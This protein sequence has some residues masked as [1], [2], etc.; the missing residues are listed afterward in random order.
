MSVSDPL[1]KKLKVYIY[2][3]RTDPDPID[4][5]H[6]ALKS[7]CEIL[8][9]I[10]RKGLKQLVPNYKASLVDVANHVE[11]SQ[12]L[13]NYYITKFNDLAEK[14][15]SI[16]GLSRHDYWHWV[17]TVAK[18]KNYTNGKKMLFCSQGRG[19]LFLRASLQKKS[20][21]HGIDQLLQSSKGIEFWYD[22]Q[23]SILGDDI[24]REILMSLLFEVN[25]INFCLDL[26][27]CAFLDQ[28]WDLPVYVEHEFVPTV[29]LGIVIQHCQTRVLV[30]GLDPRGVA[31]DVGKM[32]VGDVIN[33]VLG[34]TMRYIPKGK[35]QSLLYQNKG[36]PVR[37]GFSKCKLPDGSI[38]PPIAGLLQI[39]GKDASSLQNILDHD[40]QDLEDKDQR[41]PPHALLPEEEWDEIPVHNADDKAEYNIQFLGTVELGSKGGIDQIEGAIGKI[42]AEINPDKHPELMFKHSYTG[43]SSCGRRTDSMRYI[44]YLAGETTCSI[45]KEFV[46]YIFMTNN[47]FEFYSDSFKLKLL[48]WFWSQTRPSDTATHLQRSDVSGWCERKWLIFAEARQPSA[49]SLQPEMFPRD[50]FIMASLV[51]FCEMILGTLFQNHSLWQSFGVHGCCT[52]SSARYGG[53]A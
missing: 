14:S 4:D 3:L 23:R 38:Y 47:D 20:L 40:K 27:N 36:F 5:Q 48:N 51:R 33:T 43:I 26:R 8:E 35:I 13:Y 39:A 12:I 6:N 16:F 10:L 1:L 11:N 37:V 25:G 52:R 7:F 50:G 32:E 24:L 41:K 21:S 45:S 42:L 29:D 18:D 19:R 46:A 49:Q 22:P 17:E 9:A 28:T 30:S 15:H 44:T 2:Q 53:L 34:E 31:Y